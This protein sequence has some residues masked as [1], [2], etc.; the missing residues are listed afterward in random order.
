MEILTYWLEHYGYG[1]IFLLLCLEM[2][3]LP[4]PGEMLMSYVGLSVY[5]SK[6]NWLLSI[7]SAGSGV[8]AGV[9]LSYWIGYR[10]GR[11]FIVKYGKRVHLTEERVNHLTLWFEK[12]GAKLLFVAYFIPGV[13][14]I[15][16][17]FCGIT[18]L[19]FRRYALFAYTG[20]IFWVSLFISLGKVLGPKWEQYHSTVNRYMIILGLASALLSGIVFA[21][22][23]YKR[24]MAEALMHLLTQGVRRFNSFGK[25]RFLLLASFA[26]FILFFWLMLGVIQDFLAHEFGEFDEIASYLAA[27]IFGPK[28][29]SLM[30]V[31]AI[32]GTLYFYG[33]VL[34]LTA[35]WIV[36]QSKER[37]LD[38]AFLVWVVAGGEFLDPILRLIFHRPG[39]VAAGAPPL[40]TFPSGETLLSITVYG[41]SAFLLLRYC[42]N[43]YIRVSVVIGVILI[44][45]AVGVSRVYFKEQYPSDV[46]AG[47]VFGG[48]WVSFNVIL[49]EI[50]RKLRNIRKPSVN[51]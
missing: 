4:L 26:V 29:T 27:T 33:P 15:T 19:P 50:L 43:R 25:V 17:Y 2:L 9:T 39:P 5:E 48:V 35:V 38:L 20:A 21:Y 14:H 18:R 46:F 7:V 10:L 3:A 34:G 45:L 28:W 16:G 32:P 1:I 51:E 44:C 6:L 37:R 41:F 49:L 30:N 36:L 8:L 12:Y 22:R 40:N 42:Q 23:K 24:N 31:A 11:P 47:Y 13:R